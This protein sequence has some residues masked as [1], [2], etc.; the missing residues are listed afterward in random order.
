MASKKCDGLYK[1]GRIW[2]ASRDPLTGDKGVSTKCTD[3][4]AARM[5]IRERER[6]HANPQYRSSKQ[7]TFGE[8]ATKFL[9]AKAGKSAATVDYYKFKVLALNTFFPDAT[10]LSTID[11]GTVDDYVEFRLHPVVKEGEPVRRAPTEAT[12]AK[13]IKTLIGILTKAKRKGCYQGDLEQL[14]PDIDGSYKPRERALEPWE[15][16][17]FLEALPNNRWRAFVAVCVALGCRSSEAARLTRED[18]DLDAGVAWIDGR[19]TSSSNRTLPILSSYRSL[20]EST[21]P[22]LPFGKVSNVPRT[23]G[24]AC[25]KAKIAYLSPNDLRRTHA[26]LNSVQGLP[27]D[28][29][30]R[31]L[32]HTSVSMAKRTYNR[33]K[34]MM[35]IP[36]AERLLDQGNRI[37]LPA[38]S[39][40]PA[41]PKT[42]KA[43]SPRKT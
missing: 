30:A 36:V 28:I 25:E 43:K 22:Y 17:K 6:M 39:Y 12:V 34:S 8:W 26:T 29:I 2:W 7:A 1:R 14:H 4:E 9:A 16:L 15:V 32:G 11:S 18:I 42:K 33:A 19:K 5:W 20:L 38:P 3:L 41:T 40:D 27:D 21:L 10:S 31:L 13:E 23:F 35:L 24:L 37:V